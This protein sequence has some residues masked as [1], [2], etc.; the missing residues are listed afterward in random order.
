[1]KVLAWKKKTTSLLKTG[2]LVTLNLKKRQKI[3]GLKLFENW[4]EFKIIWR[5]LEFWK[6]F[7]NWKFE[8]YLRVEVLKIIWKV[9]ISKLFENWSY[10]N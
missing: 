2:F 9:K 5:K 4:R 10:E 1:M 7:E 3:D 8:N 6:L